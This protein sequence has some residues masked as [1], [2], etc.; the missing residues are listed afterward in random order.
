MASR[1]SELIL[2]L[3]DDV[4][5]PARTISETLKQAEAQVKTIAAAMGEGS[6]VSDKFVSSLSRLKLG[7]ADIDAIS[8]AF[9]DYTRVAG[10]AGVETENLTREQISGISSWES[11][12]LSSL[13]TVMAER[14]AE[15]AQMKRVLTEQTEAQT[16]AVE[17]QAAIRKKVVESAAGV[18]GGFGTMMAVA[19]LL[20]GTKD[21]LRASANLADQ[22]AKLRSL[23]QSDQS[24]IPFAQGLAGDIAK[25]FPNITTA[26]ALEM[27]NEIRAQSAGAGGVIDRE[28]QPEPRHRSRD[29]NGIAQSRARL[30]LGRRT[31]SAARSGGLRTCARSYSVQQAD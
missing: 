8:R 1:T 20:T 12:T 5:K 2:R 25:K 16:K 13:R 21:I 28:K 17:E 7:A 29:K 23:A 31:K 22:Q 30:H 27:Y 6:G 10:I 9:Q 3:Q 15:T 4:S 24:R 19:G 11:A 26:D 14:R 18:G